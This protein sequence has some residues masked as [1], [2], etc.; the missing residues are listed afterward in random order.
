MTIKTDYLQKVYNVSEFA[1]T[2]AK[3]VQAAIRMRKVIDYDAF[4]FT[5]TS[6]A[7]MA[8]ILSAELGVPLLCVRKETDNSH[9]VK[10]HGYLEGYVKAE[11][12]VFVDDFISS[13]DTFRR[14]REVVE[15]KLHRAKCVGAILYTSTRA[16]HEMLRD[17]KTYQVFTTGEDDY[18]QS[19]RQERLQFTTKDGLPIRY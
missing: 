11:Q 7:A 19:W 16:D 8:Y 6:G 15:S 14:V 13:G 1:H 12:Y 18:D 9:Y 2:A 17:G 10:G 3:A 5:G 4:A